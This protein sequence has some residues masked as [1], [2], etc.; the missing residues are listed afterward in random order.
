[1]PDHSQDHDLLIQIDT[2][3]G[4]AL[5]D[6]KDLKDGTNEKIAN[7][8][9]SRAG[10]K[11]VSELRKRVMWLERIAYMGMGVLYAIEFWFHIKH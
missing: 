6:I 3:L 11:E 7:L 9:N 1:M 8:E 10:T 4:R 5:A 2:K